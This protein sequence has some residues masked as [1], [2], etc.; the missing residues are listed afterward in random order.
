MEALV[1]RNDLKVKSMAKY[2]ELKKGNFDKAVKIEQNLVD[3]AA[4]KGTAFSDSSMEEH[5]RAVESDLEADGKNNENANFGRRSNNS[6]AL[7]SVNSE[8]DYWQNMS[9]N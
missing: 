4:C 8:E 1:E 5:E 9:K 3:L 6:E 2:K 7:E